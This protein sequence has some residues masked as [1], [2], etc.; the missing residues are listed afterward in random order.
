MW[1]ITEQGEFF[2][3][4]NYKNKKTVR[5]RDERSAQRLAEFVEELRGRPVEV[6]VG[7]GTDYEYRVELS[8]DEWKAFM[9]ERIDSAKA[10]NVKS[11][12][13]RNLGY[14][15]G[16]KFLDAMHDTWSI[17][18]SYQ[19]DLLGKKTFW[20]KESGAE[21]DDEWERRTEDEGWLAYQ[22]W[23]RSSK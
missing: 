13:A 10:T 16:K 11:E 12:V 21:T 14:Q 23:V 2:S 5:T 15:K 22:S 7:A 19:R 9:I 4:V 1:V 8:K 17:W 20:T 6:V 18:F 3:A